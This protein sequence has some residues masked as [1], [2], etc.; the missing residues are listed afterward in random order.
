MS[1]FN[2]K[3]SYFTLVIIII[4]NVGLFFMPLTNVVGYE[5]SA[6][7]GLILSFFGGIVLIN[8]LRSTLI[9][10]DDIVSIF[11][12]HFGLFLAI[13]TVPLLLAIANTYFF[14]TCPPFDGI[15]FYLV[16]TIPSFIIGIALGYLAYWLLPKFSYI[17]F[18][19]FYLIGLLFPV[20]E[21]YLNPQVYFYN[22][23]IGYF[24]G[25]IYDED[26][27]ISTKLIA[28]RFLT[29]LYFLMVIYIVKMIFTIKI[30]KKFLISFL[31]AIVAVAFILLKPVFGF[32]TSFGVLKDELRGELQTEHFTIHYSESIPYKKIENIALHHEYYYKKLRDTLNVEFYEIITSFVFKDDKQ[33][34]RLFGA[35]NA[36]VAKPWLNQIYINY[37][38]F[39]S[40]L[41][42]ELAHVFSSKFGV[43]IF[44]L[45]DWLNPAMI[46]GFAMA[47]EN[48]YNGNEVHYM[49]ALANN[50]G[51]KFPITSLFSGFN[52]FTKTS[53]I[54]YIYSGSFIKYLID[55]Y[56]IE[57]LKLVYGDLD[58]EKYYRRNLESLSQ[59]YY[60]FLSGLYKVYRNEANR[61]VR[62]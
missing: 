45:A 4:L 42:H 3:F 50:T 55:N 48:D 34:G 52:F 11:K 26:I 17:V 6:V 51:Y 14:Q 60:Q 36:D 20:V 7:N 29:L 46:E 18:I 5:F 40:S 25:V 35:E 54:A 41:E 47:I 27:S 22:S 62:P 23:L 49:A 43:T 16:I 44:K 13:P 56:G 57:N 61:K 38:N 21:I 24:P 1:Y 30:F 32:S 12:V 19:L 2:S 53:S 39:D 59:E 37:K 28:Y 15:L 33:K 58:F 31:F 10:R 8:L 9:N